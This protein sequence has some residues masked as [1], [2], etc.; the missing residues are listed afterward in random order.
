MVRGRVMSAFP[1]RVLADDGNALTLARWPGAGCVVNAEWVTAMETGRQ[2][3]R[4]AALAALGRGDWKMVPFRWH[5]TAVVNML[6][7]GRWF[8]V[9]RFH[10]PASG[11]LRWWYVNFQRPYVRVNGGI[12][13]LDL[14]LD[15]VVRPDLG[16]EWKDEEE[17]EHA[18]RLGLVTDDD[19]R[20]VRAARDEALALVEAVALPFSA[21]PPTWRP[22]ADW[23]VPMLPA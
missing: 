23:P 6:Q 11:A 20:A 19:H 18:R 13:T 10:D 16:W 22:S 21:E 4:D 12:G 9:H 15:L 8:S 5:T 17:Y 1:H 2:E 7:E 3:D 14:I